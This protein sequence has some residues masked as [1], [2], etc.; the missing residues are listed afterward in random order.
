MN[1]RGVGVATHRPVAEAALLVLGQAPVPRRVGFGSA[2]A[3][4]ARLRGGRLRAPGNQ[5]KARRAACLRRD[6]EATTLEQVRSR[7]H[8]QDDK[9]RASAAERFLSS[10]KRFLTVSDFD[11]DQFG[12]RDVRLDTAGTEGS[13]ALTDRD[14][15]RQT[16]DGVGKYQGESRALV[17]LGFVDAVMS[18]RLDVRQ[19]CAGFAALGD[20]ARNE[21]IC[22]PYV[23]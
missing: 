22:V 14:P 11:A 4:P 12:H 20:E 17:A 7:P 6:L 15:E 16:V 21:A 10:P 2:V 18:K 8:L 19:A 3:L 13:R 5:D 9:T 1:A 23:F